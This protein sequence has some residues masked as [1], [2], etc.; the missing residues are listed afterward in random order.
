[1]QT[2]M[3]AQNESNKL[4]SWFLASRPKTLAAAFVPILVSTALSFSHVKSLGH[5]TVILYLSVLALLSSIF[6]Q[7]GTNLINDAIDFKKGAD[8]ETRIGPKRVTQN[9]L[10]SAKQVLAG[11]FFSFFLAACLGLPLILHSGTPILVLGVVSLLCGFLY[12]GG[13]FPLAYIG[14][15]ELFVVLFFGLGAIC[16]VHFIQTGYINTD[17]IVASIQIG[18]LATVLIAINNFRD[19]K[20]DKL[21]H[22]MTLAARFGDSFARAEIVT[23][24]ALAYLLNAYWFV[25]GYFLAGLLPFLSLP[26]C[27]KVLKGIL[28]NQPS[29]LFNKFLGMSAG[30]QMLFGIGLSLGFFFH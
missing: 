25:N 30:V 2:E 16:G 8:T 14:L 24:F 4:H 17:C 3:T 26:L 5:G 6:I 28:Q 27:I 7:I 23:L 11:G 10:L 21:V 22:K 19:H 13:P 15:G 12:T 18:F 20:N 29:P 9:G 1:M